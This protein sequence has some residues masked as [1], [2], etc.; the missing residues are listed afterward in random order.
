MASGTTSATAAGSADSTSSDSSPK[1]LNRLHA[2]LVVPLGPTSSG[3]VNW[4]IGP[5]AASPQ[6]AALDYAVPSYDWRRRILQRSVG[7]REWCLEEPA[8]LPSATTDASVTSTEKAEAPAPRQPTIPISGMISYRELALS[9]SFGDQRFGSWHKPDPAIGRDGPERS[10]YACPCCDKL[11]YVYV[12][13][14]RY[15]AEPAPGRVRNH[16]AV[17]FGT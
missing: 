12:Q 6:D 9:R 10:A 7:P 5:R 1:H 3:I 17:G 14:G 15:Y 16:G 11:F 2:G 13:E 8:S 4:A